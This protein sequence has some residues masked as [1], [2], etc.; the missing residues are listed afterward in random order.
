MS[1]TK[2][3]ERHFGLS[4]EEV[5]DLNAEFDQSKALP[6]PH[7]DGAYR[8]TIEALLALEPNQ[9]HPLGKVKEQFHNA[10]GEP[11]KTDLIER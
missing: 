1:S 2:K 7:G 8:F 10:A 5:T 4:P 3:S 11:R 6:N 9:P